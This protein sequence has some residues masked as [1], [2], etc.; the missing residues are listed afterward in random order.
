MCVRNENGAHPSCIEAQFGG[1]GAEEYGLCFQCANAQNDQISKLRKVLK[2]FADLDCC[3]GYTLGLGEK[4]YFQFWDAL[5]D[6]RQILALPEKKK[7]KGKDCGCH[8]A[9]SMT[10]GIC[11]R[12]GC[13]EKRNENGHAA[14]CGCDDCF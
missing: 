7:C 11:S 5:D 9:L 3:V 4:G 6:A 1:P 10:I 8:T 12:C 13:G 2:K 14:H